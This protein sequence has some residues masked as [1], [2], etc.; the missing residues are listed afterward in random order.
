L[1]LYLLIIFLSILV[2]VFYFFFQ[3][4]SLA[5]KEKLNFIFLS[6]TLTF[7]VCLAL[8]SVLSNFL[9]K[10][11]QPHLIHMTAFLPFLF[12]SYFLLKKN[13]EK[14]VALQSWCLAAGLGRFACLVSGCC[15][16]IFLEIFQVQ[17]VPSFY[18][19][20]FYIVFFFCLLKREKSKQSHLLLLLSYT[21]FRFLNEF[22]RADKERGIFF[23]LSTSQ[24]ISIC[25]IAMALFLNAK[26][27]HKNLTFKSLNLF[28]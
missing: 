2:G 8:S 24:W 11:D 14:S 19:S 15:S 27:P 25:C 10:S 6:L 23:N 16:G 18:E 4:K 5:L 3:T 21:S 22:L 26:R 17:S 28:V 1:N 13:E 9:L 12:W 7:L 20:I